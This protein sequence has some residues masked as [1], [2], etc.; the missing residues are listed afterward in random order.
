MFSLKLLELVTF[1]CATAA[2]CYVATTKSCMLS[3]THLLIVL[4]C[5][6]GRTETPAELTAAEK[7]FRRKSWWWLAGAA[8]TTVG[9]VLLSNR[10]LNVRKEG[11]LN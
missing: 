9:Y 8:L 6:Q 4:T 2:D 11:Q 3:V 10:Y 1:P 7:E 5:M